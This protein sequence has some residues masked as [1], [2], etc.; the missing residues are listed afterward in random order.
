MFS[1]KK[2]QQIGQLFQELLLFSMVITVILLMLL[3]KEVVSAVTD[4]NVFLKHS[5]AEAEHFQ[6]PIGEHVASFQFV[7]GLFTLYC[8]K[9]TV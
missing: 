8:L 7:T 9:C 5:T 1:K 6:L 4:T 3:L 2:I